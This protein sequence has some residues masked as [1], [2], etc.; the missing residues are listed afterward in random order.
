MSLKPLLLIEKDGY[1]ATVS[2]NRPE[3]RNAL[4]TAM[5]EAIDDAFTSL[6]IDRHTRMVFVKGCQYDNR[7]IFSSGIGHS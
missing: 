7:E 2:L 6:Q 4:N 3:K 1:T 5:F